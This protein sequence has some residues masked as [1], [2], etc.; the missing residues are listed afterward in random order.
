MLRPDL[1]GHGRTPLDAAEEVSY[2]GW[3]AWLDKYLREARVAGPGI[4]VGY[5]LGGRLALAL[6]AQYPERVAGL[7][8]LSAHPGLTDPRAR[9]H[10]AALDDRR[11]R[12]LRHRG[13]RAF[14]EDW[15]AQPL[16]ALRWRPRARAAL[17][18][19]RARQDARAMA[20]VL[21]GMSPGRQPPLWDVLTRW[22]P[23]MA[24]GAGARDTKYTALARV[25]RVTNPPLMR[26]A[27]FPNA[28]HLLP[29]DAPQTLARFLRGAFA[30]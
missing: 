27:I 25:L 29:H 10:R 16:F 13:L 8:L 5:S 9:A 7:A 26:V 20:V 12:D 22:A 1:P 18:E 11:A 15:Y 24:Y 14:L 17:V 30:P 3:T 4:V 28:G 19:R 6:A 23:R 2:A 21:A